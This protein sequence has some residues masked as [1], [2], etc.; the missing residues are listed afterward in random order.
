MMFVFILVLMAIVLGIGVALML[1][2]VQVPA[3]K[4]KPAMIVALTVGLFLALLALLLPR[5]QPPSWLKRMG[6]RAT[7]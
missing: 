7:A 2:K 5:A 4:E 1:G 3:G 6:G